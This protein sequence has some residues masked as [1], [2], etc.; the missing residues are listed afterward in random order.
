[1]LAEQ[2]QRRD[3]GARALGVGVEEER[4]L[5]RG[6][7]ELV[8]AE[9]ALERVAA[10]A[11]D[12]AGAAAEDPGLRPAEELV[13]REGDETRAGG[14]TLRDERLVAERHEAAR[15]EVVDEREAVPR[16]DRGELAQRRPLGE[17]DRAEV[18]LVDAEE[19]RR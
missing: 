10:E 4:P 12:E 6:E 5:E 17:A 13:A 18:R 16:R 9:R 19:Q 11:R 7:G 15:A 2:A 14:E 1:R 3:L 8:R